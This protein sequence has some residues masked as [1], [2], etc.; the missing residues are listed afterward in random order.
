MSV[1]L[2]L[3]CY[4]CRVGVLIGSSNTRTVEEP[5]EVGEFIWRH[6]DH[7]LGTV[8]DTMIGSFLSGFPDELKEDD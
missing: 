6:K 8:S 1:L 2:K 4:D 5:D 3:V 7:K